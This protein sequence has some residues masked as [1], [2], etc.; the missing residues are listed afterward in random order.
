V[1]PG[2]GH[3][4]GMGVDSEDSCH[5]ENDVA[6][7]ECISEKTADNVALERSSHVQDTPLNDNDVDL[8]RMS[9]RCAVSHTDV[10]YNH[11]MQSCLKKSRQS[12][13]QTFTYQPEHLISE[14][15]Q[16]V[17]ENCE[18]R[19]AVS[20]DEVCTE[21][22]LKLAGLRKR[23]GECCSTSATDIRG[24]K[25][26]VENNKSLRS[27]KSVLGARDVLPPRKCK[28]M[29][30]TYNGSVFSKDS[31]SLKQNRHI[32]LERENSPNVIR[33]KKQFGPIPECVVKLERL[34]PDTLIKFLSRKKEHRRS[35][36]RSVTEMHH[37]CKAGKFSYFQKSSGKCRSIK[38]QTQRRVR[39]QEVG[40]LDKQNCD[41][42]WGDTK[43]DSWGNVR[44]LRE[45]HGDFSESGEDWHGWW[46]HVDS[47]HNLPNAQL[48]SICDG[49]KESRTVIWDN[50]IEPMTATQ[51]K[52]I[53]V[54]E[55]K[56][57]VC[58]KEQYNMERCV[59]IS[60]DVPDDEGTEFVG[61]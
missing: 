40:V 38:E 3:S 61:W 56:T 6:C 12:F 7:N 41:S 1:E 14:L 21:S 13:K 37:R 19:F 28:T 54:P 48:Y 36:V 34:S 44:Y 24:S 8:E 31:A 53:Q 15:R 45:G 9:N 39:F 55:W 47:V 60:F 16:P 57:S 42:T 20:V 10:E 26:D 35:G 58:D 2:V 27:V 52:G 4:Q 30:L 46:V 18:Q 22:P 43:L 17:N 33:L 59:G 23:K 50:A 49:V 25:M 5:S 51:N 29:H 32:N 11:E